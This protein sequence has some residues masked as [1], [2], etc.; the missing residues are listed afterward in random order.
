MSVYS[1]CALGEPFS[2][3]HGP[4][5]TSR[6]QVS[7]LGADTIGLGFSLGYPKLQTLNRKPFEDG[8]N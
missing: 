8:I 3:N 6:E 4:S 5:T 7:M 1:G 2:K